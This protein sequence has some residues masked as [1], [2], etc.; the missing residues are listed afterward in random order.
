MAT[1]ILCIFNRLPYPVI[2][3]R[4]KM[5]CQALE[6][7]NRASAEIHLVV[8]EPR[9]QWEMLQ[10]RFDTLLKRYNK[11]S[12][13]TVLGLPSPFMCLANIF[14]RTMLFGRKSLQESL[15]FSSQAN[16]KLRRLTDTIKPD[17]IYC[18]SARTAQF[19][20]HSRA[21][22]LKIFDADDLLSK[23]YRIMENMEN[24]LDG[25]DINL[26]GNFAD[27]LPRSFKWLGKGFFSRALVKI[28]ANLMYRRENKLARAFDHVILVSPVEE[29]ELQDRIKEARIHYI[30]PTTSAS[31]L[32]R[33]E[34]KNGDRPM[35][36]FM[37][38]LNIPHNQVG[39]Q[40]FLEH[41]FPLIVKDVPNIQLTIIGSNPPEKVQ[42]LAARYQDNIVFT[43]FVENFADVLRKARVFVAPIY[44]GTG[45]KTKIIDAM[46]LG[47]PVVTTPIGAEGLSIQNRENIMIAAD[48][49]EFARCVVELLMDSELNNR[50]SRQALQYIEGHHHP[51][52]EAARFQSILGLQKA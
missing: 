24:G 9:H 43:G 34:M 28:E 49:D 8:F 2:G 31:P 18:D 33:P 13:V 45:I 26:L 40:G 50:L 30:Y 35:I 36:A 47:L 20:E 39:L 37:G 3:G 41:T 42:Q 52:K 14:V 7:M 1:R 19:F 16:Y 23:R 48:D 10:Q 29:A 44:F 12:G 4:E 5:L 17:I 22:A 15:F 11:I 32:E 38:L 25:S 6:F 51:D 21:K 46:A 27:K